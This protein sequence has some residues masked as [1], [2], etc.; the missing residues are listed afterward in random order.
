MEFEFELHI[1]SEKQHRDDNSAPPR[2][3]LR[4]RDRPLFCP[5][6]AAPQRPACTGAWRRA[7]SI[8]DFSFTFTFTFT[9]TLREERAQRRMLTFISKP[10][11]ISIVSTLLPP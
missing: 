3:A 6:G 5:I 1:S 9:F 11:P 10:K 7:V 8:Y 2:G 4:D